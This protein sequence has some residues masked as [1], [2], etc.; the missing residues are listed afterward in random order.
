[1]APDAMAPLGVTVTLTV[2]LLRTESSSLD[3]IDT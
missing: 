1:M 2:P 3:T